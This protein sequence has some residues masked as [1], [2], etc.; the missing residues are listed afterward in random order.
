MTAS[1][2]AFLF[3]FVDQPDQIARKHSERVPQLALSQ[4]IRSEDRLEHAHMGE[5]KA[6]RNNLLS[7]GNL[8]VRANLRNEERE[9]AWGATVLI[10]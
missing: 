7:K 3:E 2:K 5:P 10:G 9:I 1:H 4:P 8:R 6:E